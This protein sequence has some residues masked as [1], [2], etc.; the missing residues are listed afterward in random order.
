[1]SISVKCVRFT[2]SLHPSHKCC[3]IGWQQYDLDLQGSDRNIFGL[4]AV[5][6]SWSI[7]LEEIKQVANSPNKNSTQ[8]IGLLE[9]WKLC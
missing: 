1:M 4:E 6:I 2:P 7:M 5:Y 3:S 9:Q 8:S